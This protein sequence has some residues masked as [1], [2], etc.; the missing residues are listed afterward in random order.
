MFL[1][2]H[3]RDS[4][5]CKRRDYSVSTQFCSN[6]QCSGARRGRRGA[7]LNTV[8][9]VPPPK[10]GG[11]LVIRPSYKIVFCENIFFT[12]PE[13]PETLLKR[14]GTFQNVFFWSQGTFKS[15]FLDFFK[16]LIFL[17]ILPI[18][19]HTGFTQ[20]LHRNLGIDF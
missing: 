13:H 17:C 8:M 15:H 16:K 19:D 20:E 18:Q 14:F 7:T 4:C 10:G 12:I 3:A 6:S 5:C 2:T 1:L 11:P 9:G